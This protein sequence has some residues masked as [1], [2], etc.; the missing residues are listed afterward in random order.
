M[1]LCSAG[2]PPTTD[3]PGTTGVLVLRDTID[4]N[5]DFLITGAGTRN[6][7]V[8]EFQLDIP[9]GATVDK[10]YLYWNT[11][12]T[13]L[14][15]DPT[16]GFITPAGDG[17]NTTG[18][19]IGYD[20]STCWNNSNPPPAGPFE[21]ATYLNN[22]IYFEDVTSLV[23]VSGQYTVNNMPFDTDQPLT[24]G[25]RGPG[26]ASSQGV[27]LLVV[28]SLP[29]PLQPKIK[30]TRNRQVKIYAG[31]I[32]LIAA[33]Q[34]A[35][36]GGLQSGVV[37][38]SATFLGNVNIRFAMGD[39]QS[40]FTSQAYFN[41]R[42][43]LPNTP[44]MFPPN[45]GAVLSTRSIAVL[46]GRSTNQILV[47][48]TGDCL[49]WFVFGISGDAT[50]P[51]LNLQLQN[52][53]ATRLSEPMGLGDTTILVKSNDS[54]VQG[55]PF[56]NPPYFIKVLG[57]TGDTE[58]L[59][60]TNKDNAAIQG[61]DLRL[62]TVERAQGGTVAITA[63]ADDPLYLLSTTQQ[64]RSYLAFLKQKGVRPQ[65]PQAGVPDS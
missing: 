26:C 48:A 51:V 15:P 49:C 57:P 9:L 59:K 23:N 47:N 10:A 58:I 22:I 24:G 2:L 64:L 32:S 55:L 6:N 45:R 62:W 14:S 34:Q 38:D 44:I 61:N 17:I 50:N 13:T 53:I 41:G 31:A 36:F 42:R 33:P 54:D 20:G 16:I 19:I 40:G 43:L 7:G 39:A 37:T 18:T 30:A 1:A 52:C 60:V 56:P 65:R 35:I 11:Y 21:S 25:V 12:S 29:G 3:P 4:I 46:A 63:N 28:Y 8:A 5:G 27:V